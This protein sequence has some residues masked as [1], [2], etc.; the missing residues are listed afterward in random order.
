MDQV[1]SF[2]KPEGISPP[3]I[4]DINLHG[5][6]YSDRLRPVDRKNV[7]RL[8]A[9]M[10][11]VGLINPI[12]V[13]A[14]VGTGYCVIA[15]VHRLEAARSLKWPHIA[16]IVVD[17]SDDEA[18]L[19]E[20]DENLMRSEL[21][22]AE[23]AIHIAE[24]KR[25]YEALHPATRHGGDRKSEKSSRQIGD[26][27]SDRFTSDTAAKTGTSER[28][29]QRDAA[30][31]SKI[32]DIGKVVGTSLDKGEELDAL[33]KLPRER[34]SDLINRAAKG[35][36]VSAKTEMKKV[37]RNQKER[38]LAHKQIALPEK[39][40]GVILAD[41]E[42]RFEVWS[43]ETGMDR[44]ADNHYPTSPTDVIAQ[45]NVASIA[46][47]DC[48]LFLWATAPMLPDALR[49]ME[50]WGFKYKSH[51]IWSKDRVGTGYW[52]RN[53]HELLLVGTR[54]SIPAPAMGTQ[55]A[56]V[57]EAPV[58]AH[59]AKP[60]HFLKLIEGYFPTIP[61]IEL[62]RRGPP[63]PGWDAWGNETHQ[64]A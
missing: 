53:R 29:I 38:D 51:C 64:A 49:V 33:A 54:G 60:E 56:S 50:A 59:S 5:L 21:T 45:R 27:N 19:A 55:L 26:L 58:G 41:P 46:A 3:V 10:K 48:V 32:E 24:R 35:E 13:R 31:G 44:A 22:P 18:R 2:A 30:R 47:D 52:F 37:D 42:W 1:T 11:D 39:K 8:A 40:Y 28:V 6:T 20:I 7:E 57:I 23:R 15:G 16:A 12:T 61:K 14:A 43:Q 4:R 17:A 34:Q 9:S 62:N 63:R 25:L 36:K